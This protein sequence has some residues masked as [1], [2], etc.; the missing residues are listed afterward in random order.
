M[1]RVTEQAERLRK[2]PGTNSPPCLSRDHPSQQPRCAS[3]YWAQLQLLIRLLFEL[4]VAA[5]WVMAFW[6]SLCRSSATTHASP[7]G[8]PQPRQS[9]RG[10]PAHSPPH[11]KLAPHRH[12]PWSES[13][14]VDFQLQGQRWGWGALH[15]PHGDMPRRKCCSKTAVT[16]KASL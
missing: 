5:S 9:T 14:G 8:A 7:M 13:H 1:G 16:C 12:P 6:C 11:H 4:V 10:Q 3:I 2:S 15:P